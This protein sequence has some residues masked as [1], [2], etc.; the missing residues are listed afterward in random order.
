MIQIT[1]NLIIKDKD[2][3]SFTIKTPVVYLPFGLEKEYDSY[4]LKLQLRKTHDKTYNEK[5]QIF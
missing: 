1:K 3:K 2:S 5:L 4:Y